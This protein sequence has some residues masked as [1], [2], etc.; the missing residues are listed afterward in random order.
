MRK[1][2]GWFLFG[3][4]ILLGF[5]ALVA[6]VG[7]QTYTFLTEGS[8]YWFTI[9]DLFE[10]FGYGYKLTNKIHPTASW[11]WVGVG[12]LVNWIVYSAPAVTVALIVSFIFGLIGVL[13][14]Y[15]IKAMSQRG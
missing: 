15:D 4:G 3:T 11:T 2:F 12:K 13:C 9:A 7:F 14:T 6:I 10:A 5:A 8:W 1:D